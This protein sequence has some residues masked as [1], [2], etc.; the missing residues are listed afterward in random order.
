ML[1]SVTRAAAKLFLFQYHDLS[2]R[3][4]TQPVIT[5]IKFTDTT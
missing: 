5:T 4:P 1:W 2:H 3:R